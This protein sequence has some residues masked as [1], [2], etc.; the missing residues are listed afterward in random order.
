MHQ[1]ISY[2]DLTLLNEHLFCYNS[3]LPRCYSSDEFDE[4]SAK[5]TL[6]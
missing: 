5:I 6:Q 4:E 3:E 2:I 1:M